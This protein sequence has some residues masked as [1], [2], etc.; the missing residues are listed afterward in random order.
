[1]IQTIICVVA[2]LVLAP[3]VGGILAGLDRIVSARM[4]RRVGPPLL[5]PF[6]DVFKLRSK[7]SVTVNKVQDFYVACF[8][9]FV[10][11]TGGIFFAGGSAAGYL[12]ADSGKRIPDCGSFLIQLSILSGRS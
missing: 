1:M 2:Y 7:Q 4:Q 11:V 10:L 12:Y 8:F 6:Y 5:Q 9:I 3:L